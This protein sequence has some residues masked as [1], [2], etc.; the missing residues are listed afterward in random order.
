MCEVDY[1]YLILDRFLYTPND[2]CYML[3]YIIVC[4]QSPIQGS[5]PCLYTMHSYYVAFKNIHK[6]RTEQCIFVKV[7][8]TIMSE[9]LAL[10]FSNTGHYRFRKSLKLAK[11]IKYSGNY[12]N[13][14]HEVFWFWK[15]LKSFV[16]LYEHRYSWI[17]KHLTEMQVSNNIVCIFQFKILTWTRLDVF[18]FVK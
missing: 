10:S 1:L 18:T 6:V 11:K 7:G 14:I 4:T 8:V 3:S 9:M 12:Q 13:Q 16:L 2:S 17:F 15:I 5:Q